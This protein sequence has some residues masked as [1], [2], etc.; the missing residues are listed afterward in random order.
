MRPMFSLS[1][2]VGIMTSLSDNG[3]GLCGKYIL[4]DEGATE[5]CAEGS[6]FTSPVFQELL[7]PLLPRL[8]WKNNHRRIHMQAGVPWL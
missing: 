4:I 6:A 7:S 1:L 5:R 2:Y 8:A 3:F